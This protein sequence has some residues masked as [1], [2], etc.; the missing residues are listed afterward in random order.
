MIN[1]ERTLEFKVADTGSG[2]PDDLLPFIFERFRQID[3]TT[4]RN[5]SGA[6]LGLYIVKTFVELLN[7]TISVQS[8]VG[9]GSVFTVHLPVNVENILAQADFDLSNAPENS[10]S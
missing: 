5:H 7:G 1:L 2:M 6:G 9:E 3:S 8:W 10:L 4:T